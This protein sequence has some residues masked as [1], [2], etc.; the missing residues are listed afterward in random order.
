MKSCIRHGPVRHVSVVVVVAAVSVVI[1]VIVV[2]AATSPLT[3][4]PRVLHAVLVLVLE[5]HQAR[6]R[7]GGWTL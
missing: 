4:T 7:L 3:T 6:W 2:V 5:V 1:V